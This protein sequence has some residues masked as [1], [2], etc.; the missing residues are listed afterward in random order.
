MSDTSNSDPLL[1]SASGSERETTPNEARM[2]RA[3]EFVRISMCATGIA[4]GYDGYFRSFAALMGISL[5]GITGC[6]C[7]FLGDASARDEH[8]NTSSPYQRQGGLH[9]VA[10]AA[11]MVALL[12]LGAADAA[13]AALTLSPLLFIVLSATNHIV[14]EARHTSRI[15]Y[16]RAAGSLALIAGA[17]PVLVMWG[18][19]T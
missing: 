3:C 2:I 11:T 10:V 18:A 19:L 13:L 6:E 17:A 9:L 14:S 1:G 5:A 15:H 8:W 4:F 16:C 7:I 12:L